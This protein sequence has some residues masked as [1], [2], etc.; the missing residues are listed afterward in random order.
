MNK[1]EPPSP[2]NSIAMDRVHSKVTESSKETVDVASDDRKSGVSTKA[3]GKVTRKFLKLE[4]YDGVSTPLETFLAK[5]R[6]CVKY[7][8]W[9]EE[10][11]A[12]FLRDSLNGN[13]SQVLCEIADNVGHEEI[14]RLLRNR[15]GNS[16]Q[17]ERYRA[18]LHGR[19]RRK[20]ESVQTVYQDIRRLM[21]L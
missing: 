18:E 20:G 15:F 13:A 19:R 2:P 10:E 7:N 17:M 12:I 21:A 14:I 1:G 6:N 5:Y 9:S 3:T 16:N 11:R 8:E 4:K